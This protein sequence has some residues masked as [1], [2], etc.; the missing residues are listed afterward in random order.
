MP[1]SF[2][3]VTGTQSPLED[4]CIISPAERILQKSGKGKLSREKSTQMQQNRIHSVLP[5]T[6]SNTSIIREKQGPQNPWPQRHAAQLLYKR[7]SNHCLSTCYEFII[8]ASFW[9]LKIT[10]RCSGSLLACQQL[11]QEIVAE[12]KIQS[13]HFPPS[14]RGLGI[15]EEFGQEVLYQPL[16]HSQTDVWTWFGRLPR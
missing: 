16:I 13:F 5:E 15:Q 11:C 4:V 9:C 2:C 7:F 6:Y 14:F 12:K 10:C 8:L 1:I 3:L